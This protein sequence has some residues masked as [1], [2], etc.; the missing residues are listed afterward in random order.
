VTILA[1]ARAAEQYAPGF[2]I[3]EGDCK[4]TKYCV[5]SPNY[6][7][8]YPRNDYC[9]IEKTGRAAIITAIDFNVDIGESTLT[10]N[11]FEY[12]GHHKTLGPTNIYLDEGSVIFWHTGDEGVSKTFGRGWRICETST[13]TTTTVAFMVQ[14]GP[15]TL[16]GPSCVRSPRYPK[17][18]GTNEYCS[19][20][21][22]FN[23]AHVSAT[24]FVTEKK[25]DF[26]ILQGHQYHGHD[27]P[28]HVYIE[29]GSAIEWHSDPDISKRGWE[30]CVD[31][32]T[33][34]TTTTGTITITTT[35][36]IGLDCKIASARLAFAQQEQAMSCPCDL[37]NDSTTLLHGGYAYRTLTG[38]G[39]D[40]SQSCNSHETSCTDWPV[41]WEIAPYNSDVQNYVVKGH[42]WSAN[43]VMVSGGHLL[44]IQTGSY[45]SCCY[46]RTCPVGQLG[47]TYSSC[48]SILMRR[49]V[50]SSARC[51]SCAIAK[52][53][54]EE[55]G[56]E[57]NESCSKR[58]LGQ[59]VAVAAAARGSDI[60]QR[61][62]IVVPAALFML[63]S[64]LGAITIKFYQ[65]KVKNHKSIFTE[66]LL[67]GD[68]SCSRD[69]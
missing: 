51:V 11:G 62:W 5:E 37:T 53:K 63:G 12:R 16:A 18:Y 42:Q 9:A 15:C 8:N 25:S 56:R 50:N 21:K 36:T 44:R 29:E 55:A 7:D 3:L 57:A 35:R 65:C 39:K 64:M 24:D 49:S 38:Q 46:M 41:G 47:N 26:L 58:P 20:I 23:G 34:T 66:M 2:H 68:A 33:K 13:T 17:N 4:A 6:P 45:Y 28:K 61:S 10:I 27:G 48:L 1:R 60:L 43:M 54:V 52:K 14:Y 30:I 22:M 19:I 32:T 31:S 67:G 59:H 69:T 40:G